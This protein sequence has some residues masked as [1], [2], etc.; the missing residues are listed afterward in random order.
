LWK[1]F[2]IQLAQNLRSIKEFEDGPISFNGTLKESK[3]FI[4][5][6]DYALSLL[7]NEHLE[8]KKQMLSLLIK[9]SRTLDKLMELGTKHAVQ[10]SLYDLE[11]EGFITRRIKSEK[12]QN[13]YYYVFNRTKMLY[14]I[15]RDLEEK[16]RKMNEIM[17]YYT[18]NYLFYCH[19]CNRLYDYTGAMENAFNCC[20]DRM[21]SFD[22]SEIVKKIAK[23][24]AYIKE[25]LEALSKI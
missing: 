14:K 5:I 2:F 9:K 18:S 13:I 4:S 6:L 15:Q 8:L 23:N 19:H 25:K 3:E 7:S 12:D 17:E 11:H 21:K 20:N 22:S 1:G 10:S 16:Y 24:M